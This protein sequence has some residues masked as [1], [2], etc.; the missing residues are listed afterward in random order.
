MSELLGFT[1]RTQ[2]FSFFVSHRVHRGHGDLFFLE[3]IET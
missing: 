3:H 2:R 1:Q